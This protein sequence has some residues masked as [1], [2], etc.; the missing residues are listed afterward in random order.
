MRRAVLDATSWPA[1]RSGGRS[2]PKGLIPFGNPQ[3]EKV[4]ALSLCSFFRKSKQFQRSRLQV[5]ETCKHGSSTQGA[6]AKA[7]AIVQRSL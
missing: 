7:F 1:P 5:K 6:V 3:C 2:A 4:A